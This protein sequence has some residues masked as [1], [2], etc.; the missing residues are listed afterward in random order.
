M[1]LGTYPQ[2][3]REFFNHHMDST[4]WNRF[5]FRPDDVIISTY[6]KSGTTW[7]QQIVGQ[8]LLGGDPAVRVSE[9]SPWLDLRVPS[10][11]EKF[12]L[13]DSQTHRRFIKT[14]TPLD[15][16]VFRPEIKHIYIGRDG[17][18][19]AWSMHNHANNFRP[20]VYALLN[21]SP[22]LVGP[23]LARPEHDEL[24]FF[25]LWLE[26]DGHPFWSL[27]ENVRTWWT[28]R[29]LPNV[30]MLHFAD[31]KRDLPGTVQRIAKFLEIEADAE[32]I[33]R[34]VEHSSFDWMKLNADKCAP[35]GGAIFE[36]G[37]ETFI[38]R[39]SNGR[40]QQVLTDTDISAYEE[41][42]QAELGEDCA[43]WLTNGGVLGIERALAA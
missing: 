34:V 8:L 43:Q 18:D 25:R 30:L 10:E 24:A 15:A 35:L 26:Q 27:W 7:T 40:W 36:G 11:T 1:P 3:T 6:A 28:V 33:A 9:I 42:A 22:G 37:G 5:Q 2:K 13:L 20:E 4:I 29:D 31:M 23:P 38:N 21:E 32:L 16:F 41:R 39:G 12:E 17:R 14:H 19:I